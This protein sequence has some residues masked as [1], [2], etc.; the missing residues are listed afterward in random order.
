MNENQLATIIVQKGYEIYQQLGPGLLESTYQRVLAYELRLEKLKLQ[1]E[2]P[3]PLI[4]KGHCLENSFRAD[5]IVNNSVLIELKSL[6]KVQP[7][8]AKQTLTYLRL[9]NLKLGLLINF[10]ASSYNKAVK[11]IVNGLED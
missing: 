8:H 1:T 7:V 3:I 6:E 9:T 2:H 5:I 10:G 11:R 4:W